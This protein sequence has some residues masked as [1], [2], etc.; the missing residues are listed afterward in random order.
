MRPN[1]ISTGNPK[2]NL[3]FASHIFNACPGLKASEK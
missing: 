3:I 1:D 2:L